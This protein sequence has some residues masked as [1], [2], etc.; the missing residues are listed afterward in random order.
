MSITNGYCTVI[1]F[2]SRLYNSNV[3][4]QAS[5][6]DDSQFE[7][8]IEAVSRAIDRIKN[9]EFFAT[10]ATRYFTAESSNRCKIDDLL[11][12]TTLKTDEDG[13]GTYEVTWT[14]TDYRL[15][16]YNKMPYMEINTRPSGSYVFPLDDGAVQVVG[17]FGYSSST[18]AAI[19]E[20]CLLGCMRVWGRKDLLYGIAGSAELGTL[21]VIANLKKDG[22]FMTMIDTIPTRIV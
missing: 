13:D 11:S 19:T 1:E 2:K 4:A 20:A 10:T 7:G 15:F 21:Q 22:E 6:E 8:V 3:D 12:L 16:P 5:N 18:P 14:A 17:S 9:R